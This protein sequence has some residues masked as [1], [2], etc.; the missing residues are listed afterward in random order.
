MD[1][2][3]GRTLIYLIIIGGCAELY[4]VPVRRWYLV[5]VEVLRLTVCHPAW[6]RQCI[7][8][9]RGCCIV[10]AGMAQIN[11]NVA[12]KPCKRFWRCGGITTLVSEKPL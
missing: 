12:V 3:Q 8:G 5:S 10:C 9:L 6:R 11:G 7:S 1:P 4:S 2:R